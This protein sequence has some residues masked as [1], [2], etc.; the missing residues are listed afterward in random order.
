M[1]HGQVRI[2]IDV[3]GTFTDLVVCHGA[4]DVLALH[5]VP[6][7]P[8]DIALGLLSALRRSGVAPTDIA[9][10]AHG[11]TVAT[12]AVLERKGARTGLLTTAGFR[13]LLEL[14][15][16]GR[17]S[18][19]GR[20]AAFE[21]LIP[22]HWRREVTERLD[23]SGGV[24]EPLHEDE[25]KSASETLRQEGVEAVAIAFL[26]ADRNAVHE[27]R[28][29]EILRGLWPGSPLVLGSE[30]SPFPDERLRLGTAALAAYLTP[31]M[32][33]YIESL[34]RVL[35]EAGTSVQFRFIES[36]GGSCAPDEVRGHPL[37]TILSGPAGGSMAGGALADLLG[38]PA[39]V[40]ADMG[41]TSFDVAII[42]DGQPELRTERTLEF[43][44]RV[45]IPSVDIHTAGIGGGSLVW[46]DESVAGGLQVGPES[47]GAHP[48]PACFGRGGRKPTVTDANLLL[49]RLIGDRTDLGLPPL[50]L[51]AAERAMLAEVCPGLGLDPVAAA[52]VVL[53]LAEARMAAFLRTQLAARGVAPAE[54]TLIAFG[55]AG[56]VQAAAVARKLGL[57]RVVIPY[58]ASGF[59]AL[60]CLLCPPARTAVVAAEATL[61]SLSPARLREMVSAAFPGGLRG[62]LRLALIL[63][64]GENPH[65]DLLPV[66]DVGE[67]VEARIRRYHAFTERTYGIRPSPQAVRVVRLLAVMEEGPSPIAI[68]P[69]L[70]ATFARRQERGAAPESQ[71]AAS[72]PV[73]SGVEGPNG[74][75]RVAVESLPIEEQA[76]GPALVVLPGASA[77]VPQGMPY[78]VDRW[79]NLILEAGR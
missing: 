72:T 40:T 25:V 57:R 41:G 20:Q 9:E 58:L 18:L 2:G 78:H 21:P 47:A 27:R 77:F 62:G 28:A 38:L 45:A 5:K 13:D 26:H 35:E 30:V 50:D 12:N 44:L 37:Q 4:D 36:A 7:T 23:A 55:G 76:M 63:V 1:S 56:P 19:R 66:R 16:G 48:G 49:G 54:T 42:Q 22:R 65:E 67:P 73:P 32:N 69:S 68:G 17:R 39:V 75:P 70:Q 64:R 11:T 52:R 34:K 6:T 53:D 31:L 74:I 33:R 15:D 51:E 8:Q 79:G 59:S 43:G 29:R 61:G 71:G 3:G 14:R 60:G 46:M 24:I 10:I